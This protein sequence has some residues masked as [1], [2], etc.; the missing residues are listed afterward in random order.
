MD[1]ILLIE[2]DRKLSL[3]GKSVL[4]LQ[5]EQ[6]DQDAYIDLTQDEVFRLVTQ[7]S[8]FLKENKHKA[9]ENNAITVNIDK[10]IDKVVIVNAESGMDLAEMET[11]LS[12]ALMNAVK[13]TELV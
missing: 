2:D 4:Q 7:L 6:D 10:L 12:E 3:V 1:Y 8:E 5:V 13:N 11:Q 9:L